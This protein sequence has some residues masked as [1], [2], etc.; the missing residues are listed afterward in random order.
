MGREGMR[1]NIQN[2]YICIADISELCE[3][4]NKSLKIFLD[5][6]IYVDAEVGFIW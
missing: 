1:E 5:S 2:G 4:G 6:K 3:F